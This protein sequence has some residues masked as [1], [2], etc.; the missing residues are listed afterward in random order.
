MNFD[1]SY[2][3]VSQGR[4]NQAQ[5]RETPNTF[6]KESGADRVTQMS[7]LDKPKQRMAGQLGHRLQEYL[8]DP[9][10]RARTEQWMLAFGVSNEGAAFNAA[11]MGMAP[12]QPGANQ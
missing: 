7:A 11:K 6:A 1:Y 3:G 9:M 4:K 5:A 2:S 10:E 8:S 12:G